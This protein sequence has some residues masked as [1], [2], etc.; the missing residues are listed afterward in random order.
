MDFFKNVRKVVIPIRKTISLDMSLDKYFT[1][2]DSIRF[3]LISLI[4]L[5][6]EMHQKCIIKG[7]N[8]CRADC[9]QLQKNGPKN[10]KT[11]SKSYP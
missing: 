8:N 11:Q 9:L 6:T 4:G 2:I 7:T 10:V 1:Q 5:T 3:E